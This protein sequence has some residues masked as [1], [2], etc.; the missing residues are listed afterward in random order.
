[1]HCFIPVLFLMVLEHLFFGQ[2]KETSC[3]WTL[4]QQ[5]QPETQEF[6]GL[7]INSGK[8]AYKLK[9]SLWPIFFYIVVLLEILQFICYFKVCVIKCIKEIFCMLFSFVG[10]SIIEP[11]VRLKTAAT[12]TCLCVFGLLITLLF[13]PTPW[14]I[15]DNKA[16]SNPIKW[17]LTLRDRAFWMMVDHQEFLCW[18]QLD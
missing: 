17:D 5:Q 1:M 18:S 10:V 3:R 16:V 4:H 9:T 14:H 8:I 6:F 12:F 2:V 7:F 13:R 11:E 15:S